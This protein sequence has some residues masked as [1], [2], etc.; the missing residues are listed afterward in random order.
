MLTARARMQRLKGCPTY[1][2]TIPTLLLFDLGQHRQEV[3]RHG[4][5]HADE[6]HHRRLQQEEELRVQLRLSRQR[7]QIGDFG[8]RGRAALH[9]RGLDL[10]RRR[11]LREDRQRLGERHRIVFG[12][13]DSGRPGEVR[14]E[15]L[16]RGA[17]DRPLRERV[18]HDRDTTP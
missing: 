17:L 3:P 10:Q 5:Q 11:P 16:E 13:G 4:A 7:R 8:G 9:D 15:R 6:L 2:F 12:V 18:L 1:L 14:V